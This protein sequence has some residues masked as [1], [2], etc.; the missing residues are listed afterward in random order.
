LLEIGGYGLTRQLQ[1]A[2]TTCGIT[3]GRALRPQNKNWHTSGNLLSHVSIQG[4]AGS[5]EHGAWRVRPDILADT[6]L[7]CLRHTVG[8]FH[9]I[10]KITQLCP[11]GAPAILERDQS[12]I[13]TITATHVEFGKLIPLG[14]L[15]R[16]PEQ[17]LCAAQI[18]EPAIGASILVNKYML[19]AEGKD[20]RNWTPIFGCNS[21]LHF[22]AYASNDISKPVD[23]LCR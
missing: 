17:E 19:V 9:R 2:Q 13:V 18:T 16:I 11:S 10:S 8:M 3:K 7:P 14:F 15:D 1:A 5:S 12:G 22:I 23:W 4:S 6:R 21:N 20:T